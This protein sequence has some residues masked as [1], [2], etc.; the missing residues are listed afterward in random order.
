MDTNIAHEIVATYHDMVGDADFTP[1]DAGLDQAA[2]DA[3][4]AASIIVLGD[5]GVVDEIAAYDQRAVRRTHGD[6]T[7][8]TV[9]RTENPKRGKS[10]SRFAHYF[11]STTVGEY[12]NKCVADGW[13][14]AKALADVRWD[15]RHGHIAAT[16]EAIAAE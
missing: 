2:T 4:V 11:T 8:V 6:T 14:R 3:L 1:T 5:D 10:A 16:P 13:P 15:E 7:P 9:L 12:V